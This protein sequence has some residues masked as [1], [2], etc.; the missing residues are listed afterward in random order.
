MLPME[1]AADYSTPGRADEGIYPFAR[2]DPTAHPA[3][4]HALLFPY[5]AHVTDNTKR[6]YLLQPQTVAQ[7]VK[8]RVR[9]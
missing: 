7:G 1:P 6:D 5:G 2:E 9:R 8:D 3:I 4:M